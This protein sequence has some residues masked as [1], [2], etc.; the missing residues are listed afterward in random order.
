MIALCPT[1]DHLLDL[2]YERCDD[3]ADAG[4]R[5]VKVLAIIQVVHPE[6][7]R[8]AGNIVDRCAAPPRP[9]RAHKGT[10]AT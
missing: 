5:A 6:I 3:C 1:H 9:L 8:E 10:K 7:V 2:D 4:A